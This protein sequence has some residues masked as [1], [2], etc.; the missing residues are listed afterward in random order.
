[1]NQV[2]PNQIWVITGDSFR[3]K[4][5]GLVNF[6]KLWPRY[7]FF[8]NGQ[9]EKIKRIE[10]E[11][12]LVW[13]PDF[14]LADQLSN[15]T[16]KFCQFRWFFIKIIQFLP[17]QNIYF[18]CHLKAGRI[19]IRVFRKIRKSL[20]D[21]SERLAD[22]QKSKACPTSGEGENF[23]LVEKYSVSRPIVAWEFLRAILLLSLF[24]CKLPDWAK[25][26]YWL[27]T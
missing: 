7:V 9:I 13:L 22:R 20:A 8:E 2:Q 10:N 5:S 23:R 6:A 15:D 14:N 3:T 19:R 24:I 11:E 4:I 18:F 27:C 1:M 25:N 26:E 16:I 21:V 12:C 17:R